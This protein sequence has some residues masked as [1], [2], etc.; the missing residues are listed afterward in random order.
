M[1]P[2]VAVDRL[3]E[4]VAP[5]SDFT[6]DDGSAVM[7]A[8]GI[9]DREADLAYKFTQLAWGRVALDGMGIQFSQDFFCFNGAGRI[10][11]SGRL[12]EQ[13]YFVAAASSVQKYSKTPGFVRLAFMS[14]DVQA[15]NNALKAGSKP[16]NL[17]TAT[18]AMFIEAATPERLGTARRILSDHLPSS[19]P[20]PPREPHN[21]TL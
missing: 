7:S 10:V 17:V 21:Q 11:E 1:S 12:A 19:S 13:P 2:E 4:I 15:V 8:V 14:P 5:R 9:P 20:S 3:A 16:E 6:E 18:A